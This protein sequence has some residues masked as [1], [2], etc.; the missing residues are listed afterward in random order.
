VTG[1]VAYRAGRALVLTLSALTLA[2][3]L[4]L[5][6]RLAYDTRLWAQLTSPDGRTGT[7]GSSA[8]RWRSPWWP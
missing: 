5:S 3:L 1:L 8:V 2:H 4:E 6:H 7:S